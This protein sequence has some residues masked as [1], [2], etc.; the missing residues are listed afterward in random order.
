LL[1]AVPTED[2]RGYPERGDRRRIYLR[3]PAYVWGWDWG[4]TWRPAASRAAPNSAPS[5]SEIRDV[6]L[7]TRLDGKDAVI[8]APCR[9][10]TRHDGV[11][12]G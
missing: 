9:S 4:R 3:K 7:V 12:V 5:T 10:I 2:S 1:P 11:R 8:A 6:A